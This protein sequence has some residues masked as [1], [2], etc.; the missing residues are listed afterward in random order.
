MQTTQVLQLLKTTPEEYESMIIQFYFN[1]CSQKTANSRSLQ[2][3]L[4]C[5]PLF[6][7]WKK[8]LAKLEQV[9]IDDAAHYNNSITKI[10]AHKLYH[11]TTAKLYN[12]FSKPLIKFANES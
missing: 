4:T 8:E 10:D 5:P 3:V 1:W 2:K 11:I 12:R 9:F 6:N 7:W